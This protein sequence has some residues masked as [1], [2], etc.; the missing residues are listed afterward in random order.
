M[1]QKLYLVISLFILTSVNGMA[2]ERMHSLT[3]NDGLAGESVYKIFK[4][5]WGVM[6]LATTNGVSSFDGVNITNYRVSDKRSD[7]FV[8]DI[9]QSD[10]G[11][12]WVAAAKG[13]FKVDGEK[14]WLVPAL[15]DI[16]K[17]V[18]AIK[19]IGNT[20]YIGADNGLYIG[21]TDKKQTT[22]HIWLNSNH[23]TDINRVNDIAVTKNGEGLWLLGNNEIYYYD[24]NKEQLTSLNL[25]PSVRLSNGM[26]Y[27]TVAKGNIYIGTYN[28]GLWCYNIK[29]KSIF[30]MTEVN[31]PVITCLSDDGTNLYVGTDGSGLKVIDMKTNKVT[32]TYSTQENSKYQLKDNTVYSFY[33]DPSGVN[34][35]G[36]FRQGMNYNYYQKPVFHIYQYSTFNSKGKNIR[37]LY[38]DNN[39]KV[40]GTRNGLYYID[41][42]R[43][44]IKYYSPGELGGSIVTNI[45]KYDGQ[46]YFSMFNGGVTRLE[47]KTLKLSRFGQSI[48]LRTGSFGNLKV[49]PYN[50]LWMGGNSGVFVY[51]ATSNTERI[52]NSTNSSLPD[53]YC[54]GLLFDRLGRCWISSQ[55]GVFIFD[56]SDNRIHGNDF[57]EGFF[58]NQSE[59]LGIKGDRDNLLFLSVDGLFRTNEEMTEYGPVATAIGL[60]DEYLSQAIYDIRNHKYWIAS[61]KGITCYDSELNIQQHFSSVRGLECNDF[62]TSAMHIEG[63]TL[64]TGTM[65]GLY[66]A[67][68]DEAT[69][70]KMEDVD[71]LLYDVKKE[72]S[73]IENK[74]LVTLIRQKTLSLGFHWKT[75]TL[76]FRPLLLNYC[77]QTNLCFEYRINDQKWQIKKDNEPIVLK[78][79]GFGNN[80]FQIRI[81]GQEHLSEYTFRVMPSALFVIEWIVMIGILFIVTILLRQRN[82]VLRERE[83]K[84]RLK[85]TLEEVKRKYQRVQTS[86]DEQHKLYKQL[87]DYMRMHQPYLNT[88]LKLS[89]IAAYLNVSTVKLSQ[90]LNVFIKQNYYDFVNKYR[91]EE[92]KRRLK[93]PR[94]KNY[95]LLALAE[96]CGF[97]RSSF[98]STFKKVEGITPTEYIKKIKG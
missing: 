59:M 68:I 25:R 95:T 79:L 63:P 75:N 85:L 98:F 10:D 72:N 69:K 3:V 88:D 76:S 97:K 18:T 57:P 94:Y 36:Y 82:A 20:V 2:W 53:V 56:P 43:N 38:I 96:E 77:D 58:N 26:R 50:E 24:I 21:S 9:A 30:S 83:E 13:V 8:F 7:N 1:L 54:N 91:L 44:I 22:K 40:L 15:T 84:E 65:D 92:F 61:E 74:D 81:A 19:I 86:D 35:F 41:E 47:P 87:D 46:Y 70:Y 39:V 67:D 33:H 55:K 11:Y 32:E 80:R 14:K 42:E 73:E 60:R 28:D 62:N 23:I 4:S 48:A 12:I 5:R 71:I 31:C 34:F 78:K 29:K 45:E 93:E 49:S 16:N 66:Y 89:D 17:K 90:L 52:Y 6:W 64:W 37:S 51:N 27:I